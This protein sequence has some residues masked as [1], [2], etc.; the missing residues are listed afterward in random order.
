MKRKDFKLGISM[1]LFTVLF[2]FIGCQQPIESGNGNGRDG[3]YE[4]D[5]MLIE[6]WDSSN[7]SKFLGYDTGLGE[8]SS[9][10]F[11]SRPI[12]LTSKGYCV[13][14][15]AYNNY[16]KI[17]Y[18]KVAPIDTGTDESEQIIRNNG[19]GYAVFFDKTTTPTVND[20][21]YAY[22]FS[23]ILNDVMYNPY[24]DGTYYTWDTGYKSITILANHKFYDNRGTLCSFNDDVFFAEL[25]SETSYMIGETENFTPLKKIGGYAE[26]GLPNPA[27]VTAPLVYKVK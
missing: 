13:E 25:R 4:K 22:W 24:N 8:K 15:R 20:T 17:S 23:N 5:S 27:T 18:G 21:S 6:V 26:L 11:S 14:L 16:S 3:A 9:Y 2:A 19:W 10:G 7:P 1:I 12:I